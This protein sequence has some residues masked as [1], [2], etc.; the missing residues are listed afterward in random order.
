M[1]GYTRHTCVRVDSRGSAAHTRPPGVRAEHACQSSVVG[2]QWQ[3]RLDI[4]QVLSASVPR[5]HFRET[6]L[7]A[8]GAAKRQQRWDNQQLPQTTHVA[9]L[10]SPHPPLNLR[11]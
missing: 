1:H 11:R 9:A 6:G 8:H 7:A 5:R 3:Q 4:Q 10:K 2:L